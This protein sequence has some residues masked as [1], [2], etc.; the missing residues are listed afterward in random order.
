MTTYIDTLRIAEQE[1]PALSPDFVRKV[2]GPHGPP[3]LVIVHNVTDIE[4]ECVRLTA[5]VK[6]ASQLVHRRLE[7]KLQAASNYEAAIMVRDRKAHAL[8]LVIRVM[9]RSK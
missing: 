1:G 3:K 9:G 7:D 2:L 6:E 5:E 8:E 4:A